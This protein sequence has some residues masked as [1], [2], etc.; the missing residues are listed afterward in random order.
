MIQNDQKSTY[1]VCALVGCHVD[2]EPMLAAAMICTAQ[3]QS[4]DA[5]P[6]IFSIVLQS[7][8]RGPTCATDRHLQIL[9]K[10]TSD[11]P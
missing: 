5:R 10:L 8:D 6:A 4:I 7:V 11:C 9:A 1:N 2:P 3:P